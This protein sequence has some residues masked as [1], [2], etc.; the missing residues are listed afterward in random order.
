MKKFIS[1]MIM[2]AILTS[3]FVP[4][5]VHANFNNIAPASSNTMEPEPTPLPEVTEEPQETVKD[6]E[7]LSKIKSADP[8]ADKDGNHNWIYKYVKTSYINISTSSGTVEDGKTW[9]IDIIEDARRIMVK[10][11]KNKAKFKSL[12]KKLFVMKTT[13]KGR[14]QIDLKE[15]RCGVGYLQVS[16]DGKKIL[17]HII[18]FPW[19]VFYTY[20]SKKEF[21]I[22]PFIAKIKRKNAETLT[23]RIHDKNVHD[24]SNIKGCKV[25]LYYKVT[26]KI[27]DKWKK[28]DQG[29]VDQRKNF[30]MKFDKNTN[31]KIHITFN[32]NVYV[33]FLDEIYID[34][35]DNRDIGQYVEYTTKV[36]KI[37]KMKKGKWYT[38]KQFEK[39]C[40][41]IWVA[42]VGYKYK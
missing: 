34:G 28:I 2:C 7:E 33:P 14:K 41:R 23:A 19:D 15:E 35:G 8:N 26:Q 20:E 10:K 25:N 27:G 22:Y 5:C 18:M 6:E 21:D 3:V 13:K 42:G 11:W 37:K 30:D 29:F 16:V 38:R 31:D 32:W 39:N 36:S 24:V 1:F 12:N 40:K 17:I 4:E 9:D